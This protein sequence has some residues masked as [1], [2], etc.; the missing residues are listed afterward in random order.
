MQLDAEFV[1][2]A[3]GHP[4]SVQATPP[5]LNILIELHTLPEDL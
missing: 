1:R 2:F 4:L 3:F 5:N